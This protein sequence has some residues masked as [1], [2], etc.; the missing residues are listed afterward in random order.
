M[1]GHVDTLEGWIDGL[2]GNPIKRFRSHLRD[3]YMVSSSLDFIFPLFDIVLMCFCL[4]PCID[5][6][7]EEDIIHQR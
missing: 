1:G 6:R 7:Q 2:D 4:R 5:D 3:E